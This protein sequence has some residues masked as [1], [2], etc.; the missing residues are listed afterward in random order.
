MLLWIT[1]FVDDGTITSEEASKTL[2]QKI[3]LVSTLA[4]ICLLPILGHLGDKVSP[5]VIIP[6]SFMMRGLCGLPFIWIKDPQLVTSMTL[7]CLLIIISSIETVSIEV[8]FMRGMPATIRGTMTGAFAFFGNLGILLFALIGGQLFDRVDR[9]APFV[10]MATLDFLLVIIVM[11][12]VCTG[13]FK[14]KKD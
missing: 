6:I 12:L 10:F 2:Y 11:V 5:A 8:L 7:C 9:S 1:S 3:V 14:S 4:S 13:N